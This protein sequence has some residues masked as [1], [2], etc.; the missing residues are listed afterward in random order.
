MQDNDFILVAQQ[1]LS[2]YDGTPLLS[3]WQEAI[4][5]GAGVDATDYWSRDSGDIVNI[6]WLNSDGIRDI[7]MILRSALSNDEESETEEEEPESH[8]E[9]Y[10]REVLE[11]TDSEGIDDAHLESMFNFIP[12]RSINSI[13]VREGRSIASRMGIGATGDKLVHVIP[14]VGAANMG[15][16]YWVANSSSE[17]EE[18]G[19]FV[20]SVLTA[21]INA[22]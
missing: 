5:F 3:R 10:D 22:F 15:H 1:L 2:K 16:L 7:T 12:L 8:E 14:N 20:K 11:E 9:D 17:A 19:H 18:L 21:Y 4:T 13:E 6:V